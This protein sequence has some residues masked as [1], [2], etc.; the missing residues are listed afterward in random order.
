M[1]E[2]AVAQRG[3]ERRHTAVA[4]RIRLQL[5]RLAPQEGAAD[6]GLGERHGAAVADA[7]DVQVEV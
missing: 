4:N 6:D 5:E 3:G 7:V 1:A 2:L